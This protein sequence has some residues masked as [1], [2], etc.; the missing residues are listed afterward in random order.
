[1]SGS[2]IRVRVRVCTR[3]NFFADWSNLMY[4]FTLLR[5]RHPT[6]SPSSVSNQCKQAHWI[7]SNP[8]NVR[9]LGYVNRTRTRTS[10]NAARGM[11][12]FG[13]IRRKTISHW[14]FNSGIS[15]WHRYQI[16][17]ASIYGVHCLLN[18]VSTCHH[19]IWLANLTNQIQFRIC[20]T[21][22]G[23]LH[24][25][26][27]PISHLWYETAALDIVCICDMGFFEFNYTLEI[28]SISTEVGHVPYIE[29][30]N[31]AV[32]IICCH[33]E[34]RSGDLCWILWIL[35]TPQLEEN[36]VWCEMPLA[37]SVMRQNGQFKHGIYMTP[38]RLGKLGADAIS[39]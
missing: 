14:L 25:E 28:S 4:M 35:W 22:T 9:G 32:S 18:K 26:R 6:Y 1:M 8:R 11:L 27:L 19:S 7:L 15:H 20:W 34:F 23:R 31:I 24:I 2:R 36:Q 12:T 10:V 17:V 5:F 21:L 16:N 33:C 29:S 39:I 13:V 37:S 30:Y 38:S 3:C